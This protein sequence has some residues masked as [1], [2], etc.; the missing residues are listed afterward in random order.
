MTLH[1]AT[2]L[3]LACGDPLAQCPALYETALPASLP[4]RPHAADS[5]LTE[6]LLQ[7]S[8]HAG[9]IRWREGEGGERGRAEGGERG[10][11]EGGEKG[12]MIRGCK[13]AHNLAE[14][15]VSG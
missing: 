9:S 3:Y 12:G 2:P 4:A 5:L 10:R 14:A 7:Y 8:L 6:L 1:V 15:L 11:V 13:K